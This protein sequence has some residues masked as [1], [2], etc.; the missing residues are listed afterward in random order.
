MGF[1]QNRSGYFS[2]IPA[3]TKHL[4]I[5]NFLCWG[6]TLILP[7]L[8]IDLIRWCG[9]HFPGAADFYPFQ[10]ITYMFMHDPHSIGHIFFNMFAVFMFGSAL[11][12]LWGTKRYLTFYLVSGIGAALVQELVWLYLIDSVASAHQL[13]I[14]QV[15]AFNPSVNY[16]VTIGASG[17]VFGILLGF[18]MFFPNTSLYLFFIPVPIKAKYF[19]VIYGVI[20]LFLGVASLSSDNVAHF[21]HLGGMLFG[22][23]MI[24]YWRRK[25][26]RNGRYF[27]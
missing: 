16:M 21:A 19:V 14:A 5:I 26:R 15:V 20:E 27:Y 6:A 9:L 17:A 1:Q 7:K 11:E 23:I 10:V 22:F 13:S 24:L 18:G 8:H 25:D 12:D 2:N 4:I 3:V